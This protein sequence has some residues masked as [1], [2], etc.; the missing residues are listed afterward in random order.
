MKHRDR[1]L[2]QKNLL[3]HSFA[4][5]FNIGDNSIVILPSAPRTLIPAKPRA[6]RRS[7]GT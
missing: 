6:S 7:D 1:I 3:N 5:G 2:A 4:A